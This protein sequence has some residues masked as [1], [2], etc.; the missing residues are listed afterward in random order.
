MANTSQGTY[1][2][3]M[4]RNSNFSSRYN[5]RVVYFLDSE[6]PQYNVGS[7]RST[8][9]GIG[10]NGSSSFRMNHRQN[11]FAQRNS[12]SWSNIFQAG[13]VVEIE[14][15]GGVSLK[16]LKDHVQIILTCNTIK[17]NAEAGRKPELVPMVVI[18][19]DCEVPLALI[20][21]HE[22]VALSRHVFAVEEVTSAF[23]AKKS[24]VTTNVGWPEFATIGRSIEGRILNAPPWIRD[25]TNPAHIGRGVVLTPID[26][27][28][29]KICGDL[30]FLMK[31]EPMHNLRRESDVYRLGSKWYFRACPELPKRKYKYRVYNLDSLDDV[32]NGDFNGHELFPEQTV[33]TPSIANQRSAAVDVSTNIMEIVAS[34]NQINDSNQLIEFDNEPLSVSTPNSSFPKAAAVSPITLNL[35]S[36]VD[37]DVSH[38]ATTSGINETVLLECSNS[39]DIADNCNLL[40]DLDDVNE[41][42]QVATQVRQFHIIDEDFTLSSFNFNV[43]EGN[44]N[45]CM[46]SQNKELENADSNHIINGL[47][48]AEEL[49]TCKQRKYVENCAILCNENSEVEQLTKVT[50]A[51][52]VTD[53]EVDTSDSD[54]ENKM[55]HAVSVERIDDD[56]WWFTRNGENSAEVR[57][58]NN[59][60]IR[61]S[62]SN[63]GNSETVKFNSIPKHDEPLL[64]LNDD[65]TKNCE[66]NSLTAV[67]HLSLPNTLQSDGVYA[68]FLL[69]FSKSEGT[70]K[71]D[72]SITRH[73]C[74]NQKLKMLLAIYRAYEK[75][76]AKYPF[77][78]QASSAGALAAIADM[79]TQNFIEKRWQKGEYSP[80]RTIRFSAIILFWIAPVT[81]RWFLLLEKLKGNANLLPLKRMI[82]DQS[83]AAPL[84]TFSFITNLRILEGNSPGEALEK[85]KMILFLLC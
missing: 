27:D 36:T 71:T 17:P 84:F 61:L 62:Y 60:L 30:F 10:G 16:E 21:N 35:L 20:T 19:D 39:S 63:T 23:M 76:L 37:F 56:G 77:L 4:Y 1:S 65:Q 34:T 67:S 83:L 64:I 45:I 74:F 82:L 46:G 24:S 57:K 8:F 25:F 22:L 5:H 75:A 55:F 58:T 66:T 38:T 48:T 72:V 69:V 28:D 2:Q 9:N 15:E 85:A 3:S 53:Q 32:I 80:A 12:H 33:N 47:N 52:S 41:I 13:T 51:S 43:K 54:S 40:V 14:I 59:E 70:T 79:L 6:Y 78:T 26:E 49:T 44:E 29:K 31:C 81:Y 73:R 50:I 18:Q 42:Q 68:K 11:S 7:R